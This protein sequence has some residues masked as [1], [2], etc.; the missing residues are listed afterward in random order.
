[1]L[2]N[3]IETPEVESESGEPQ[4]SSE[5]AEAEGTPEA[6]Q[7]APKQED[8]TPFH[9]HPRFKELV[10]QKNQAIAA[11]RSLEQRLH[12]FEQRLNQPAP[13]A[14]K[15]AERDELI[16]DLKKIDPRLASRLEAF[17][18]SSK[19]TE[20]LQTRLEAFEKAQHQQA[21]QQV[22]QTAVG[23]INNLHEMNKVS[24]FQKK[25]IESQLDLAY[26]SGQLD[27]RDLAKVESEY[28]RTLDEA[29]AYEEELK[30]ETLK[31]YVP[32]KKADSATPTSQ[33]KGTPAK[34]GAKKTIYSSDPEVRN[35]QIV[36]EYMKTQA[37]P[38]DA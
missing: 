23:K 31:S 29:K 13:Q 22:L 17:G 12:Q 8:T 18:N 6:A 5:P 19:T 28:K 30:R 24:P 27:A 25:V 33:P 4:A 32:A 9:E 3:E 38:N 11:Q 1:M 16:E 20:Q 2:E 35:A 34:P 21:Q 14:Q 36:A 37:S 15:Q 7:A 10:E 26:R